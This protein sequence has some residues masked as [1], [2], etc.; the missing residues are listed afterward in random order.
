LTL[1]VISTKGGELVISNAWQ[2]G[3]VEDEFARG[4]SSDVDTWLNRLGNTGC[5]KFA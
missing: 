1:N 5:F 2:V 3:T 4:V